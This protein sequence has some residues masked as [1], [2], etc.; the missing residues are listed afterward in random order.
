MATERAEQV[1]R[2]LFE[3]PEGR[4]DP[5]PR[6]HRLRDAAPVHHSELGMWLVS[7]YDGVSAMLRDPR[8]G[9]N[10]A[11]QMDTLIGP[12]WREHS[13]VR[14]GEHSMLN[15]DGA[16][17]TR[18]R[19]LVVKHFKRRA[20]TA[21]RPAIEE[22]VATL[23]DPYAEAGGGDLLDAVAFPLPVWVIGELL[24]VPEVDRPPF[25]Y[26]VRDLV[27]VLEVN[28]SKEAL[29]IADT[30]ADRIRAY[31]DDLIKEKRR[32]PQDDLLSLLVTAHDAD[33]LNDDELAT[34]ASLLFGAG[35]ET[36]TNL[37]GNGVWGLLQHPD[38]IDKLREEPSLFP[39]L[40]DEILRYDGTA[41][42]VAR[43]T[44][45]EVEIGDVTIP[46]G[47]SV[48]ALLGA[49]NH[50]PAEFPEPDRLDVTRPRFRTLALG[51]GVHFCLGAQ[52]ARAEIEITFRSLLEQF[53]SIELTGDPPQ[54][55]DRLTLRGLLSLDLACRRGAGR[56]LRAASPAEERGVEARPAAA[57]AAAIP[58]VH[59]VR[60]N[61]GDTE[62]DARWR[63]ALR[64]KVETDAGISDAWVRTGSELAQTIVLL[65]RAELFRSCTADEIAELAA[66][67]YPMSF[68]PGDALCVEGAESL[69]CYAISEGEA[70]VRI[71]GR[72][73]GV[74]GENDVVGERG[75]LED[76]AR[77]ATVVATSHVNSY[78]ISR[79]RLLSLV[80]KSPRAG[81][82]MLAYVRTRYTD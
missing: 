48:M 51:G 13:A 24:G 9:K 53:D 54:F 71:G 15:L 75:L 22:A 25:R 34:L 52:L 1:V 81:E 55:R 50:D 31:F 58:D 36:T 72:E 59:H 70:A 73:I 41:Q 23:L 14:R 8:F 76:R 21:L 20:I 35:F 63:N 7:T 77:S 18:L 44:N 16:E 64:A 60:P 82:G 17:H 43:F 3:T 10:Y 32:R 39:S 78:A 11:H 62:A 12:D 45:A 42:M 57:P 68:E 26:W 2:E 5:Y 67:A 4:T 74:V 47:E 46:A 65:A 33:R 27:A 28:P 80:R 30:A 29:N 38:Q 6:Y 40:P 56:K 61:P 69:E 66:T 79:E 49:G 19:R 37:I